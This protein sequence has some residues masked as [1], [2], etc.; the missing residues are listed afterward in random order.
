MQYL[1]TKLFTHICSLSLD[2]RPLFDKFNSD[3]VLQ[4][5]MNTFKAV[6]VTSRSIEI[7]ATLLQ[8]SLQIMPSCD[9]AISKTGVPLV[10]MTHNRQCDLQQNETQIRT[11]SINK[12]CIPMNM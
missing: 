4:V 7:Y 11:H 9:S 3:A 12:L 1:N 5:Q 10:H 8:Q 2:I 6:S